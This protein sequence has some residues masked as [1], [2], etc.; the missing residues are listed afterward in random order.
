MLEA[1]KRMY[2]ERNSSHNSY[3]TC[4]V[5]HLGMVF[6]NLRRLHRRLPISG[7]MPEWAAMRDSYFIPKVFACFEQGIHEFFPIRGQRRP[8]FIAS[9]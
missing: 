3:A 1:P 9:L 4:H 2:K 6:R 5:G 7:L 8:R